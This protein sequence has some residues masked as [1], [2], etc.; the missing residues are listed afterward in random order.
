MFKTAFLVLPPSHFPV[1]TEENHTKTFPQ[2]SCSTGRNFYPVFPE[3]R[4]LLFT[5]R[6]CLN[7]VIIIT[8]I[9]III[10]KGVEKIA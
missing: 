6:S 4:E 5:R 8:I 9:V 3:Y 10:N 7:F 1:G 2:C